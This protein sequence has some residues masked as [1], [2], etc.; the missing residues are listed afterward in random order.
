MSDL[1][2]EGFKVDSQPCR[3][4]RADSVVERHSQRE[5]D[6]VLR[7]GRL[8][9]RQW[10]RSS[11]RCPRKTKLLNSRRWA[12]SATK[13]TPGQRSLPAQREERRGQR[14]Y[15]GVGVPI[16]AAHSSIDLKNEGKVTKGAAKKPGKQSASQRRAD[17]RRDDEP[18]RR[19][20]MGGM[21]G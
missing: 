5:S 20:V 1:K 18:D 16:D 3:T 14:G 8:T 13:L 4:R 12:V 17:F 10:A 11:P 9:D 19:W 21:R 7:A 15:L 2:E 6:H